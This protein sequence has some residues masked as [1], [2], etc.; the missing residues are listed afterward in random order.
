MARR[1]QEQLTNPFDQRVFPH[2]VRCALTYMRANIGEKVT[3]AGL[4]TA[5]GMPERTLLNQFRKFV[6]LSPLAYLLHLR[7]NAVRDEL[8]NTGDGATIADIASRC[9]FTHLGR[10]ATAYR[11]VFRES[12]SATRRRVCAPSDFGVLADDGHDG[13]GL[14][15]RIGV[16][17]QM[18]SLVVLPLSTETLKE[19]REA[20]HLT[21]QL[22]A[23][24]SRM[25][26]GSVTLVHPSR[27][28]TTH[29]PRPRNAGMQYC[30][31]GRLT[32]RDERTRVIVRLIDVATERHVWGDSFDGSANDPFELCDRVA[33]RVL[34]NVVASI[35]DA[36][37][38]RARDGDG[39]RATV[40]DLAMR[41]LP[42]IMDTTV[43]GTRKAIAILTQATEL[44]PTNALAVAL[45]A[46][47]HAQLQWRYGAPSSADA[48]AEAMR[49][50]ARAALLDE[51]DPLVTAA[52]A[53]TAFWVA[54]PDEADALAARALAQDPTNTWAWERYGF[55]KLFG[56]G[57]PE[58]SI[59]DFNR[60]LRLRGTSLSRINCL[61]GIAGAHARAGRLA[62][63]SR[64]RR[65]A[66]AENPAAT[67]LYVMDACPTLEAGDWA[68]FVANVER[69]RR[70]QPELSI[71]LLRDSIHPID[72]SVLDALPRAGMPLT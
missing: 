58:Q 19:S 44:G 20:R 11:S 62:E 59:A 1:A 15:R 21:E 67:W 8:L 51:G 63:A 45:L 30:L 50:S 29:S 57:D 24:L 9:G 40:R 31:T 32:Q 42:L 5:C 46:A 2:R 41:A 17:R 38:I 10:F 52:R 64:W 36:E 72:P 37:I 22:A 23:T 7:L 60:A 25:R 56:G 14:P 68:G 69:M 65:T 13:S 6:G 61:I 66:L 39:D 55:A 27:R 53:A 70:G 4:A 49:L 48:C 71:A 28:S 18:P 3:L 26:V 12:P 34:S 43:P 33:D 47:C 35:T 16:P 54:R